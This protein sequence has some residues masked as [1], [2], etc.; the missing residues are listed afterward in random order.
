[1]QLARMH[2]PVTALGYG[3]RIGIWTQGC[4]I[5]C[6]GCMSV[7][8]WD[9]AAGSAVE[10]DAVIEQCR[11]WAAYGPIDGITISGGEPFEQPEALLFLIGRLRAWMADDCR[12]GDILCY[13]GHGEGRLRKHHDEILENLDAVIVGPFQE[14]AGE[15]GPLRGTANQRIM[16]LTPLG[17]E[18][19]ADEGQATRGRRSLQ[20]EVVDGRLTIIGVPRIGDLDRLETALVA[21]G[22][23]LGR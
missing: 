2:Y 14:G 22:V 17:A 18:R 13:S 8:T 12:G 11:R 7:E 19:Y 4:S 9:P 23:R 16:Q 15:G 5:G 10:V 20:L 6:P 1:M 3:I 21:D